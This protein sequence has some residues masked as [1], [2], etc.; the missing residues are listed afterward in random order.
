MTAACLLYLYLIL[1]PL[2][3]MPKL[4]FMGDKLQYCD[5]AFV[6]LFSIFIITAL[7]GKSRITRDKSWIL[8]AALA[9]ISGLSLLNSPYKK[10]VYYD[11]LGLFYL[12]AVFFVITNLADNRKILLWSDAILSISGVLISLL[13]IIF[14]TFYNFFN[15]KWLAPFMYARVTDTQTAVLPF[16]R[17]ASLLTLPEMFVNFSL[18]SLAGLFI[19]QNRQRTARAKTIAV[20]SAAV[21]VLATFLAFG[22]SS[23]G[24]MLLCCATTFRLRK[25]NMASYCIF[26]LC[27]ILFL[28][29]FIS[30]AILWFYTIAPSSFFIDS[31]GMAHLLFNT[32]LDTRYYL[33]KA[34]L[35]MGNRHPWLGS[36]LGSFTNHFSAF[37]PPKDLSALAARRGEPIESLRIDPHSLY[38]GAIAEIGWLGLLI[39]LSFIF[40]VLRKLQKRIREEYA[41]YVFFFAILGFLING[42][43][44]D[45]LSM[46][47][48]WLALSLG[49]A[50]AHL[51]QE[52]QEKA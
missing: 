30:A 24:L 18:L 26:L 47:S 37:L 43:F 44:V 7:K 12:V 15:M 48:L 36:G 17:S 19:L 42:L 23:I 52:R 4:S 11:T 51:T 35:I 50:Y 31:G 9:F 27:V 32:N 41:C 34:G 2:M 13:G 6:P 16:H 33:A 28:F 40:L 3:R 1:V 21:V 38:Y 20:L 46:R 45:V 25:K 14:F 10:E 8:P 29:L 22:R 5:L 49:M 39:L